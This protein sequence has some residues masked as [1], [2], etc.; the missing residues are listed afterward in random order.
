VHP[1]YKRKRYL[2][3]R[4]GQRDAVAVIFISRTWKPEVFHLILKSAAKAKISGKSIR[5]KTHI[6]PPILSNTEAKKQNP[7]PDVWA[8]VLKLS[9]ITFKF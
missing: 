1:K 3:A 9:R 7:A 8:F 6:S 4:Q 5:S 2:C